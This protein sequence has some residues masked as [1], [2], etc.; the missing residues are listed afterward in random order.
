MKKRNLYLLSCVL[1]GSMMLSTP[2]MAS[3]EQTIEETQMVE[4]ED[5]VSFTGFE[6]IGGP[7]STVTVGDKGQLK[8]PED[9]YLAKT[10]Y[11]FKAEVSDPSV[12]SVNE[13]GEWEALKPGTVKLHYELADYR[14]K[15]AFADELKSLDLDTNWLIE[16][17]AM[18]PITITVQADSVSLYRLYNPNSGEHFYTKNAG[19]QKYLVSVGW[20]D[21]GIGWVAPT[22]GAEVYRLYNPNAGDHHYTTSVGERDALVKLGWNNEGVC[23]YSDEEQTTPLYRL[24]NPNAVAG[25]HHYTT[26]A[27]EKNALVKLG[28]KD[29]G[30]GWYA[31]K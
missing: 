22:S 11:S 20:K 4:N 12:L 24:Y 28:W 7:E 18:E 10:E 6:A 23:W 26:S 1:V 5:V 14:T 19:E 29:E 3:T 16:E 17:V 8:R 9:H 15:K 31:T 27:G 30:I 2:I 13:K 21:E 25:A